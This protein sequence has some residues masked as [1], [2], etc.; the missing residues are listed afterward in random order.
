MKRKIIQIM[1]ANN[2]VMYALCD[3]GTIWYCE[4][5]SNELFGAWEQATGTLIKNIPQ[6]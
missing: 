6:T 2:H 5:Q 3:D 4:V 1:K